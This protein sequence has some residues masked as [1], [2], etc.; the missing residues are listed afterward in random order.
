MSKKKRLQWTSLSIVGVLVVILGFII[1]SGKGNSS[2]SSSNNSKTKVVNIGV[3]GSTDIPIWKEINKKLAKEHIYA[4]VKVFSDGDALNQATSNGQIDI[5]SFQHYAFLK[6]EEQQKHYKFA[7]I[8]Q[9]Y[10]QPLNIYSK[11]IKSVKELKDGDKIAIPNNPTNAG[12]ALKVLE[13]AGLIKTN[14]KKG[15]S[16]TLTDITSNPK[17]LKIIEVDPAAIL[18]LLPNFAAGIT[19]ANYVQANH[20]NPAKDS[21]F[22]IA[23]DLKD[24][25]NKPWINVLVTRES[26][27]N[28][29][30]FKKVVKAYNSKSVYDLIKKEYKGVDVP[31]FNY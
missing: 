19:N 5:N 23:P 13:K 22:Q 15:Y 17:H 7:V 3:T 30:T 21:I 28:N 29:A 1:F 20:M 9:T 24:P 8:G 4:K 31:A 2:S 18:K 14:P 27:K 26:E 10:I 11:K 6:Q 16:P 25:Y 12:R